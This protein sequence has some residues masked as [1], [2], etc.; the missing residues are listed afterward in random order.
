MLVDD[1][2]F[3]CFSFKFIHHSLSFYLASIYL[4][5]A[6]S[7][8]ASSFFKL[9]TSGF[10]LS[11]CFEANLLAS[12]LETLWG[13]PEINQLSN[14]SAW[15]GG[16]FFS[17]EKNQWSIYYCLSSSCLFDHF[18]IKFLRNSNSSSFVFSFFGLTDFGALFE[19]HFA[20][21]LFLNA[22][23]RDL[24]P[25]FSSLTIKIGF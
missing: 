24:L 22:S 11:I 20:K 4:Y 13:F 5:L 21:L 3:T 23:A 12:C 10:D 25:Y 18:F 19:N 2:F 14:Y 8:Q 17:S 15:V 7:F 9:S 1:C 16:F 6:S